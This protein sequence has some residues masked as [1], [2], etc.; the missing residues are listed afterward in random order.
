MQQPHPEPAPLRIGDRPLRMPR[1]EAVELSEILGRTLPV[2]FLAALNGQ[3]G[4]ALHLIGG[5]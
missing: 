1:I 2:D 4:A 5:A 3:R